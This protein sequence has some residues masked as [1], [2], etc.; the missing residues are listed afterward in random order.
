MKRGTRPT[1]TTTPGGTNRRDDS[2]PTDAVAA[3]R[4]VVPKVAVAGRKVAAVAGDGRA[5]IEL[6][7]GASARTGRRARP[8]TDGQDL[9]SGTAA[10][11]P[12]PSQSTATGAS[13][14]DVTEGPADAEAAPDRPDLHL[15][16][17][18]TPMQ[19][20]VFMGVFLVGLATALVATGS[21]SAGLHRRH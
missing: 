21:R 6:L 12:A 9:G 7:T 16:I 13:A 20:A 11:L 2:D 4:G 8:A 19:V 5:A 18:P 17:D 1:A 10:A 14:P 3:R 15:H